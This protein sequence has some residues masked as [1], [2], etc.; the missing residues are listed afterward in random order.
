MAELVR[1][2]TRTSYK[3]LVLPTN[4]FAPPNLRLQWISIVVPRVVL[5]HF[6]V[7][8]DF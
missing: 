3:P 2:I 4:H 6:I 1:G 8:I 5:V 7:D